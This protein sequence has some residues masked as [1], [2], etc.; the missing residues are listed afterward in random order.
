MGR[1]YSVRVGVK[2]SDREETTLADGFEA[3]VSQLSFLF[4]RDVELGC[5]K[6]PL[7]KL[8]ELL[9]HLVVVVF[10]EVFEFRDWDV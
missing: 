1:K 7:Q 2:V 5:E 3:L 4:Q 9:S 8:P 6:R 10:Q